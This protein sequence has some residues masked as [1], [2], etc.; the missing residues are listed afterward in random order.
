M[1]Q[2][3]LMATSIQLLQNFLLRCSW[4]TF[5]FIHFLSKPPHHA[6][7]LH[8]RHYCSDQAAARW[9]KLFRMSQHLW[10]LTSSG[11]ASLG[12]IHQL[13]F[14]GWEYVDKTQTIF[15]SELPFTPCFYISR[16]TFLL[17]PAVACFCSSLI[18]CSFSFSRR[19]LVFY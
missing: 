19:A 1:A 18:F 10:Y 7:S 15:C 6:E 12:S 17:L 16:H 8:Q 2:V 4:L 9:K 11:R 5:T 13:H 14:L 3:E